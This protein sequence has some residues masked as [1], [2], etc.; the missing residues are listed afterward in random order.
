[1]RLMI[2]DI[3]TEMKCSG[4]HPGL[5]TFYVVAMKCVYLFCACKIFMNVD[6]SSFP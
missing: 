5:S 2:C 3:H 6:M 1:M 4:R